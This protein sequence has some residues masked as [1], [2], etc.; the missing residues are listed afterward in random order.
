MRLMP[1]TLSF[2]SPSSRPP[3]LLSKPTKTSEPHKTIRIYLNYLYSVRLIQLRGEN[4]HHRAKGAAAKP[5]A[6]AP[7]PWDRGQWSSSCSSEPFFFFSPSLPRRHLNVNH[8]TPPPRCLPTTR[9]TPVQLDNPHLRLPTG[10]GA[11]TL[12]P[13]PASLHGAYVVFVR[14]PPFCYSRHSES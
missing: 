5:V 3:P 13:T 11:L 10:R 7:L 6:R 9:K 1:L 12:H 4:R 2:P 14:T 8:R